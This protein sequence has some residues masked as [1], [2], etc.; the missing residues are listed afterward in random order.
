[1]LSVHI[2]NLWAYRAFDPAMTWGDGSIASI[3]KWGKLGVP[4]M[5]VYL[6]AIKNPTFEIALLLTVAFENPLSR[7]MAISDS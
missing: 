7:K 6:S 1:M 3:F 2:K 4:A 5:R